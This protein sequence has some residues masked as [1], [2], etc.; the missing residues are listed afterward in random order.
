M[1]SAEVSAKYARSPTY[2]NGFHFPR[3][4]IRDR[5]SLDAAFGLHGHKIADIHYESFG[6]WV[7]VLSEDG[8]L[9]LNDFSHG[10]GGVFVPQ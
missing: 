10:G 1:T 8:Q 3:A 4:E 6:M 5:S 7:W 2:R 9:W